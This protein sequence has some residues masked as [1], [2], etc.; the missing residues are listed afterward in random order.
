MPLERKKIL[1]VDDSDTFVM[2]ICIILKRMGFQAIPADNGLEALRML[3][4]MTPDMVM[5]DV[6]MPTMDGISALKLI[7]EN[8]AL[9]GVPVVMVSV[10]S[11][12]ETTRKCNELGCSGYLTK[13]VDINDLHFILQEHIY[14]P[15]GWNRK[16]KRAVF[17]SRVSVYHGG[18]RHELYSES[19][20]EG[21]M[22]LRKKEP[23]PVGADVEIELPLVD[24]GIS[25]IKGKVIYVKGLYGGEF[26]VPPGMGIQFKGLS[27]SDSG[28]LADF[29]SRLIA[30]DIMESQ[31]EAVITI[32]DSAQ[33][34][35][36]TEIRGSDES[37]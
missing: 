19:L 9:A 1:V 32:D 15:L 16:H 29:V 31:E 30:S 26:T 21:G 5:L 18:E 20:S 3:K 34:Q 24:G 27:G 28:R 25:R 14:L 22:Y 10:D 12:P 13:P 17:N 4:L 37:S 7:R 6:N 11:H 2:Y 8:A 23:L 33:G 35:G 36:K